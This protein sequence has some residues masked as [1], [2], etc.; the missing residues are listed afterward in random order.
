MLHAVLRHSAEFFNTYLTTCGSAEAPLEDLSFQRQ[1]L[2]DQAVRAIE[3]SEERTWQVAFG[4]AAATV[5]RL[6]GYN[7]Q[8]PRDLS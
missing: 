8:F 6:E 2:V 7:A 4:T 5:L 3:L 1:I